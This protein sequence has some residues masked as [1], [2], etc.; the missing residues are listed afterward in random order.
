MLDIIFHHENRKSKGAILLLDQEKAFDRVKWSFMMKILECNGFPPFIINWVKILYSSPSSSIKI[1]NHIGPSFPLLRGVRQGDCISPVLFT[2]CIESLA[3]AIR[4]SP[5]HGFTIPSTNISIKTLLYADDTAIFIHSTDEYVVI[6]DILFTYELA[7]GAKVNVEKSEILL[8]GLEKPPD[9]ILK[10][11]IVP[12][13]NPIRYLGV[14]IGIGI[15]QAQTWEPIISSTLLKFTSWA[16]F[17]LPLKTRVTIINCYVLSKLYYALYVADLRK[18][19]LLQIKR[20]TLN[21]LWS[22]KKA[23]L[24]ES[25][26][27]LPSKYGGLGVHDTTTFRD[28]FRL[29]FLGK[30]LSNSDSPSP[31]DSLSLFYL[32]NLGADWGYGLSVLFTHVPIDPNTL[33]PTFYFEIASLARKHLKIKAPIS[34]DSVLSQPLFFNPLITSPILHASRFIKF[35]EKGV[36]RVRDFWNDGTWMSAKNFSEDYNFRPKERDRLLI[37]NSLPPEWP[38]LLQKDSPFLP[39]NIY[40]HQTADLKFHLYKITSVG[41]SCSSAFE[42]P[43]VPIWVPCPPLPIQKSRI[44]RPVKKLTGSPCFNDSLDYFPDSACL[45]S[46]SLESCSV[47]VIREHITPIHI[48][49]SSIKWNQILKSPIPW[50]SIWQNSWPLAIPSQW[51]QTYFLLCHQ[52]LTLGYITKYWSFSIIPQFCSCSLREEENH[53]HLFWSCEWAQTTFE[54]LWDVWS[55]Y[56]SHPPSFTF[57]SIFLP[58]G[59]NTNFRLLWMIIVRAAI[60]TIWSK[61]NCHIFNNSTRHPHIM[62][63][64][65]LYLFFQHLA[66]ISRMKKYNKTY[67]KYN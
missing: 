31:T 3:I 1:N 18:D 42:F 14:Y 66:L 28:A 53:L 63:S 67:K 57:I 48:I 30:L 7:S 62:K 45:N 46:I 8:F 12:P 43:S 13:G 52:A 56:I 9:N 40:G 59:S 65:F 50:S 38:D 17:S 32:R 60:Y 22:G 39:N 61:R 2:L 11:T 64:H 26:I 10:I 4:E 6:R 34:K 44:L 15:T 21:F 19:D 25:T 47:A 58:H 35:T 51:N 36:I 37:I 33:S 29:N 55:N 20:A 5:L 49:R 54:T 16:R 24:P 41:W 27:F 23:K